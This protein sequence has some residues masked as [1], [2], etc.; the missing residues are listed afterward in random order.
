MGRGHRPA[1]GHNHCGGKER[2]R[3]A[4]CENRGIHKM[5]RAQRHDSGRGNEKAEGTRNSG[6]SSA[7]FL[8]RSRTLGCLSQRTKKQ[9]KLCKERSCSLPALR[10]GQDEALPWRWE[11]LVQPFIAPAAVRDWRPV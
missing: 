8:A 9:N 7:K 1:N 2:S 6:A 5:A 10:A 11:K 4:S 3:G